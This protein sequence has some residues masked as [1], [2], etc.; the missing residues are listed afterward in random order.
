VTG[1]LGSGSAGARAERF[2]ETAAGRC[3]AT[4]TISRRNASIEKAPFPGL[5]P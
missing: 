2:Q 4:L 5:F 3:P 1:F